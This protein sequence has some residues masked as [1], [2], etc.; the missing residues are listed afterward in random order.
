MRDEDSKKFLGLFKTNP[1][2]IKDECDGEIDYAY[3]AK[4]MWKENQ[5]GKQAFVILFTTD[6]FSQIH[7]F[8]DF[9]D[10]FEEAQEALIYNF[11]NYGFSLDCYSIHSIS[12]PLP[13]NID[14]N[15]LRAKKN[16]RRCSR[17][18]Q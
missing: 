13:L 17:D 1:N 18:E 10:T 11:E 4:D 12:Y 9:Y 5:E 14:L 3:W 8:Y 6:D 2:E 16:G 7:N 15:E